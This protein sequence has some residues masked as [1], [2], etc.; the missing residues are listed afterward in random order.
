MVGRAQ[1]TID[2]EPQKCCRK[3]ATALL[4]SHLEKNWVTAVSAGPEAFHFTGKRKYTKVTPSNY[5]YPTNELLQMYTDIYKRMFKS[6]I[7]I[8][9]DLCLFTYFISEMCQTLLSFF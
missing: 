4:T 6:M 5:L 3:R 9:S 2:L 7:C 1:R 8:V